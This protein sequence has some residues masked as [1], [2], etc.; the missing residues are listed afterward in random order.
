[1]LSTKSFSNPRAPVEKFVEVRL[2]RAMYIGGQPHEAGSTA[3]MALSDAQALRNSEPPS[4]E[5]L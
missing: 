4:V 2:R 5:I 1:M 3:R